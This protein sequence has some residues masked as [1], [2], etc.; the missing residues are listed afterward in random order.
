MPPLVGSGG[1]YFVAHLES[2]IRS[3][4]S[5]FCHSVTRFAIF[6]MRRRFAGLA[7][8]FSHH[9]RNAVAPLRGRGFQD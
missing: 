4:E 3:Y 8:N 5:C 7:R 6:A 2:D 9:E 1:I